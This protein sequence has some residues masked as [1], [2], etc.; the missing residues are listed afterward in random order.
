LDLAAAGLVVRHATTSGDP[1]NELLVKRAADGRAR[2]LFDEPR[3]RVEDATCGATNIL[4][5]DE[6]ARVALNDLDQRVVD[7]LHH[8]RPL[9]RAGDRLRLVHRNLDHALDDAGGGNLWLGEHLFLGDVDARFDLVAHALDRF[10]T[11]QS[12]LE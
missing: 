12:A 2:I 3:R 10:L 5:E 7:G 9:R 11:G 6:E 4:S 8:Q 1:G